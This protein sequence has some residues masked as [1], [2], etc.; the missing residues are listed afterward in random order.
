MCNN[1]VHV[2]GRIDLTKQ[3]NQVKRCLSKQTTSTTSLRWEDW[4]PLLQCIIQNGKLLIK[5]LKYAKRKIYPIHT[6][7]S[8]RNHLCK[9]Q[10]SDILDKKLK[11]VTKNCSKTWK[12]INIK[13]KVRC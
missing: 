2:C 11:A 6:K 7:P 3:S 1:S 8:N 5:Y 10:M 9:P 13:K 4:H 12:I